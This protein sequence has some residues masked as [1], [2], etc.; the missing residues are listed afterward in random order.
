MKGGLCLTI[1]NLFPSKEKAKE[2][3]DKAVECLKSIPVRACT[4]QA[5]QKIDEALSYCYVTK[6]NI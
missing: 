6:D 2:S 4:E 3:I 1:Q 5:N